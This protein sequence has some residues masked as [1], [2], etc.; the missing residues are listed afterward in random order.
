MILYL[1]AEKAGINSTKKAA[2]GL[3]E[4]GFF[5]IEDLFLVVGID[6]KGVVQCWYKMISAVSCVV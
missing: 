4:D 3:G 6:Y 5:G 1:A 2:S